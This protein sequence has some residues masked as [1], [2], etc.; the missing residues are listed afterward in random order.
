[1]KYTVEIN[2]SLQNELNKNIKR[3][4]KLAIIF[5]SIGLAVYIAIS[6]F[7]ENFILELLSWIFIALT[8]G[9]IGLLIVI[10]KTNKKASER[11]LVGHYELFEDH[12]FVVSEKDGIQIS[13]V[14]L[15]YKDIVKIKETENYIF[16]Y[17]DKQTAFPIQKNK[18]TPE[19]LSTARL[20]I[21][22][23]KLKK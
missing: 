11:K 5:G 20:W 2:Q 6:M 21:N 18:L 8:G 13:T 9:G 19:E 23:H 14:T 10:N 16:L 17:A 3:N 1:M 22:T 15:F 4:C 12:M 7:V